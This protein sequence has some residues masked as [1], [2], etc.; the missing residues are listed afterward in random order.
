MWRFFPALGGYRTRMS[1]ADGGA[2]DVSRRRWILG[3]FKARAGGRSLPVSVSLLPVDPAVLP[4]PYLPLA[5]DAQELVNVG[6]SDHNGRNGASVEPSDEGTEWESVPD[7]CGELASSVFAPERANGQGGPA[8]QDPF[9]ESDAD[10]EDDHPMSRAVESSAE[11]QRPSIEPPA[12]DA[13]REPRPTRDPRPVRD[14]TPGKAVC[15]FCGQQKLNTAD[16]CPR[17]TMEDTPATRKPPRRASGRGMSCRI[18]A[19]RRRG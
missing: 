9:V 14:A 18:A 6:V 13:T 4:P 16:P 10:V 3:K 12:A 17:C 5:A 15:P 7:G 11:Q 1:P 8:M 19:P 2:D